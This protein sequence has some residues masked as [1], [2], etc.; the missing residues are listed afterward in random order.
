MVPA[1]DMDARLTRIEQRVGDLENAVLGNTTLHIT[2]LASQLHDL[3]GEIEALREDLATLLSWRRDLTVYMRV[4]TGMLSVIGLTGL[5]QLAR[6]FS[7]AL[8]G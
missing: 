6:V 2:G 4:I 1:A 5:A 7:D 3:G 8:G